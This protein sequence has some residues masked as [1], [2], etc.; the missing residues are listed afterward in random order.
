MAINDCVAATEGLRGDELT[1]LDAT[2]RA[3]GAATLSELRL[4]FSKKLRRV[5]MRGAIKTRIE[6]YLVKDVVDGNSDNV[7]RAELFKLAS[8]LETYENAEA[9]TRGK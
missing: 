5:S 3:A 4:E 2:L 1:A 9:S 8:M 6:Y 7:E